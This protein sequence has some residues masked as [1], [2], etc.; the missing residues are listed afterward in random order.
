MMDRLQG[1]ENSR[2]KAEEV[3]FY[4]LSGISYEDYRRQKYFIDN[5]NQTKELEE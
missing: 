1:I 2:M 3:L 5:N 4:I